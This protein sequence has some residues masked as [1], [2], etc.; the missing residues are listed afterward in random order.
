MISTDI[1]ISQRTKLI[2][3]VMIVFHILSKLLFN[4]YIKSQS[5]TA[6][7]N[8]NPNE[9]PCIILYIALMGGISCLKKLLKKY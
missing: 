9:K 3:K 5:K 4:P 8:Q 1:K 6:R 7:S 2:K